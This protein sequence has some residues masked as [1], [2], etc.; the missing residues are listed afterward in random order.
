[1]RVP[2]LRVAALAVL[3][4]FVS[5]ASI[6][7]NAKKT[8]SPNEIATKP[9]PQGI[10]SNRYLSINE[11]VKKGDVDLIF[12]GDSITHFWDGRVA[13]PL[14]EKYYGRRNA[15][16]LGIGGD[17]TSQVLWRLENGNIDGISP[18]LA[19]ILIGTNNTGTGQNPKQVAAGITAIVEKVRAKLPKTK[20][21][22]IG[23]FPRGPDANNPLRK[24]NAAVNAIIAK[25]A[26]EKTVFYL[27]IGPNFLS[28]DG[29]L[30]K[31][32]SYDSLHLSAKGYEIWAE[33]IEPTVKKLMGE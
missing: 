25:L 23:I 8:S 31:D 29:T 12:I 18:K 26:D 6:A 19:V 30:S 21:L 22:L 24:T 1:M 32:I 2:F 33:S 3:C 5:T 14:W 16:N 28:A 27:D 11:R 7:Q 9:A 4:A 13:G 15:V 10:W 17:Q 20:I